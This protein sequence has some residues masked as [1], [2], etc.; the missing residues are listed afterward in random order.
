M[1]DQEYYEKYGFTK[2]GDTL[3]NFKPEYAEPQFPQA[4]DLFQQYEDNKVV[5][6]RQ[7][8][9][10]DIEFEGEIS[11]ISTEWGCA[12]IEIRAGESAF[13]VIKCVHCPAGEDKWSNEVANVSVG[14]IVRI[15][16]YYSAFSSENGY[17]HLNKCHIIK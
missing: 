14:Q 10:K 12:V 4:A 8:D 16:G 2:D 3:M 1:T 5:F 11:S 15:K 6:D 7:Y 9:K 17:M 13:N